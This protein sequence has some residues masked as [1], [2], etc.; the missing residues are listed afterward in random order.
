MSSL[1]L[2]PS[3]DIYILLLPDIGAPASRA[4]DTDLG[5]YTSVPPQFLGLWPW[6][7]SYSTT[8]LVLGPLDVDRTVLPAFLVLKLA[9]GISP[10]L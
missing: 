10:M 9:C 2:F 6:T 4:L 7:G 8:S 5:T 1:S 3:W